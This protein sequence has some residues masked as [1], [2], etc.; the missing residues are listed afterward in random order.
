MEQFH[1]IIEEGILIKEEEKIESTLAPASKKI[2]KSRCKYNKIDNEIR[3]KIIHEVNKEGKLLIH[4][5][6]KYH[7]NYSSAK[8][9]FNLYRKEGRDVKKLKKVKINK[10]ICIER[11]V[12]YINISSNMNLPQVFILHNAFENQSGIVFHNINHVFVPNQYHLYN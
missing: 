4:V 9:I 3:K 12:L 7:V 8:S 6:K 5:A 1:D 11:P 2:K 10:V